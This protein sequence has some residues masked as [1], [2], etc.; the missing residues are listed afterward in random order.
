MIL[1]AVAFC[2]SLYFCFLFVGTHLRMAAIQLKSLRR[3]NFVIPLRDSVAVYII[4]I[5][6][7]LIADHTKCRDWPPKWRKHIAISARINQP[8]Q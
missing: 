1:L 7:Y 6:K 8:S 2:N 5:I 3:K 4:Y